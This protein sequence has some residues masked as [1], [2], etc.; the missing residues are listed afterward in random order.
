MVAA[1]GLYCGACR[2]LKNGK[3]PGCLKNEKA[4]WCGIRKCCIDNN[5]QSCADCT[6]YSN[7]KD[8]KKFNNF[9]G[10]IIGVILNSNRLGCINRIGEVGY[11]NYAK[12]MDEKGLQT[13][14]RR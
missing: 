8:C 5:Y 7:I 12:E 3:C 2:K 11:E 10:K 1:C 13:L 9:M 14:K 6:T 4:S